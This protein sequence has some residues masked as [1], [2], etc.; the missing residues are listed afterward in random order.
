MNIGIDARI[1]ERKMTGIGRFLNSLLKE[2][3]VVDKENKYFLF[4]Y[5]N[6]GIKED[7]Y[8]NISTGKSF[9]PTK[10]FAPIW[11]NLVIPKIL[12]LNKINLFFS[13]NQLT[14]LR[15]L[16]KIKYILVLHDVIYK[17]NKIYHPFI[18]RKYL[19]F[20]TFFSIRKSDLIVT[21]SNYSKQ[22]ILK[23][24]RID[25]EKIK[26]VYPAA[27]KD[28]Y[29]L[30]LS[31]SEK[32]EI[33]NTYGNPDHIILYVGVIEN[34][35]NITG[36]I[37]IADEVFK[38]NNRIK[39]LLIGRVGYGGEKILKEARKRE[40]ISHIEYINDEQLKE[41]Y[42]SSTVFLFPSFY[43]GFG[44]PPLEAMQSGLPVLASNTTS[45]KEVINSGGILHNPND[46]KSFA[47][48]IFKLI[49]NN[50][51][52]HQ[53]RKKGLERAKEFS[54]NRTAHELVNVF[55]SLK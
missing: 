40:N 27:E 25:S 14:P 48:D 55:N 6:L 23:H 2:L 10:L 54:I 41:I 47:D 43:E 16:R 3:P 39:F 52:F 53:Q 32:K 28:F 22:D 51:L 34:R 19:Q 15:K 9:I 30:D 20:F 13:I 8:T 31:N 29:S 24:Y 38:K 49:E 46:Y 17:V 1:L 42:N 5:E 11:I 4:T 37:K 21:V 26:V 44:F 35:K 18:Y 45:L 36:I 7:F 33:L 50:E 12:K